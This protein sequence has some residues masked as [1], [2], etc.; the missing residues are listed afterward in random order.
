[1]KSLEFDLKPHAHA[2]PSPQPITLPEKCDPVSLF[3]QLDDLWTLR[4]YGSSS[5]THKYYKLKATR[6]FSTDGRQ[7]QA[8]TSVSFTHSPGSVLSLHTCLIVSA[9]RGPLSPTFPRWIL[10]PYGPFRLCPD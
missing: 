4:N 10:S 7:Q 9:S 8:L 5:Q 1:M 2:Q 6:L 3:T